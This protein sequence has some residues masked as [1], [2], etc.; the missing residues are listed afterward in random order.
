MNSNEAQAMNDITKKYTKEE[1][2]KLKK[3]VLKRAKTMNKLQ[4]S[5]TLS[6][7]TGLSVK[8]C[9]KTMEAFL[10]V[11]K[12]CF[13]NEERIV[14][15]SI[16]TFKT[17]IKKERDGV[18]PSTGKSIRIPSRKMMTFSAAKKLKQVMDINGK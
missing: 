9:Y 5:R 6:D 2:D 4:L 14:F 11:L 17:T 16:G 1:L 3:S 15:T 10:E 8:D 18:N 13:E 12:E 7:K